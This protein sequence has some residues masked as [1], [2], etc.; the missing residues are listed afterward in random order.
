MVKQERRI[1]ANGEKRRARRWSGTTRPSGALL[2]PPNLPW[3]M[4]RYLGRTT[5]PSLPV[6]WTPFQLDRT[7]ASSSK[8]LRHL[9]LFFGSSACSSNA[10]Y[11]V[12][13]LLRLAIRDG[14]V[15]HPA[16]RSISSRSF[17]N[18]GKMPYSGA[19]KLSIHA[20]SKAAQTANAF[21]QCAFPHCR[22]QQAPPHQP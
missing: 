7:V 1:A 21:L 15:D 3:Q 22:R 4:L 6:V 11:I 14:P 18:T 17:P 12:A 13:G 5:F 16:H 19:L 10:A 2:D 20:C 8:S 9:P